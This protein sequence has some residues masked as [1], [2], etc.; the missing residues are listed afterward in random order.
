MQERETID[1][2]EKLKFVFK[3]LRGCRYEGK[4]VTERFR[5]EYPFL[6]DI[7]EEMLVEA[8]AFLKMDDNEFELEFLRSLPYDSFKVLMSYY[9]E[10]EL[11]KTKIR[12]QRMEKACNH[13]L[14]FSAGTTR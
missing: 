8:Q 10:Q 12:K 7:M 14:Q 5:S 6:A 2:R 11:R 4:S 3:T 1:R 9:A 13:I